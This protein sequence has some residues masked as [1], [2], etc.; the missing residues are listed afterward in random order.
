M[1]RPPS[2][3]W[4]DGRLYW[5][6]DELKAVAIDAFKAARDECYDNPS[7]DAYDAFAFWLWAWTE[8]QCP[9]KLRNGAAELKSEWSRAGLPPEQFATFFVVGTR[10]RQQSTPVHLRRPRGR[11]RKVRSN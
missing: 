8:R 4:L 3:P 7:Q 11:P 2:H 5:P 9:S 1:A 10:Q 6:T